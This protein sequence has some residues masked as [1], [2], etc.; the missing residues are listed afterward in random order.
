[1]ALDWSSARC[2]LDVTRARL[3]VGAAMARGALVARGNGAGQHGDAQRQALVGAMVALTQPGHDH[4]A[5]R[6]E[7]ACDG[8]DG[9]LG[10]R[11]TGGYG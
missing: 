1:M 7:E 2:G 10:Q 8:D 4:A 9:G 11:R 6:A 5:A 3:G